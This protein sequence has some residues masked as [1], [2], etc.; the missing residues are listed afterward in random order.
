MLCAMPVISHGDIN[1][2]VATRWRMTTT[3]R[4]HCSTWQPLLTSFPEDENLRRDVHAC[5]SCLSVSFMNLRTQ[6]GTR[7]VFSYKTHD[8]STMHGIGDSDFARRPLHGV[9]CTS[10]STLGK[11]RTVIRSILNFVQFMLN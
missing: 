5:M 10:G 8:Q 2:S 6:S 3:M 4:L 9:L 1:R 11:P 7:Q